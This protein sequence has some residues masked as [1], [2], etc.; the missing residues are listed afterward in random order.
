MGVGLAILS[1]GRT[2]ETQRSDSDLPPGLP[3]VLSGNEWSAPSYT[4]AAPKEARRVSV[5]V[6]THRRNRNPGQPPYS[7]FVSPNYGLDAFPSQG[8][9]RRV[10]LEYVDAAGKRIPPKGRRPW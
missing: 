9:E 1:P 3:A 8:W 5:V 2:E 4:L 10:E 7:V 6:R